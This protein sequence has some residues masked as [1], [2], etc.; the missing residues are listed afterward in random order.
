MKEFMTAA[1]PWV[2]LGLALAV[3]MAALA[4]GNK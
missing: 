3:A 1:L 2:L 4:K